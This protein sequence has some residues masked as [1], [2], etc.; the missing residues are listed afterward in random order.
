MAGKRGARKGRREKGEM[1]MR[2]G[3]ERGES[4]CRVIELWEG[5]NRRLEEEKGVERD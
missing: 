3:G 2:E 4:R 1:R 5:G